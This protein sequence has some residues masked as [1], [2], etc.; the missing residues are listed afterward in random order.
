MKRWTAIFLLCFSLVYLGATSIDPCS[1]GVRDE[2]APICH[3]FCADGCS[4]AVV[5]ES[6]VPPP[7]D[8]LPGPVYEKTVVRPVLCLDPEPEKEPPRV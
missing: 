8:A 1:E 7:P 3:V 2:C 5:P 6:P 4:T